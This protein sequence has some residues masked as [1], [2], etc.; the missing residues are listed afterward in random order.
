MERDLQRFVTLLS[1]MKVDRADSLFWSITLLLLML[2]HLQILIIVDWLIYDMSVEK[3]DCFGVFF[4][5][6]YVHCLT[7]S[8]SSSEELC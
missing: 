8:M 5:F 4:Q 6:L 1:V 3:Y 2:L 7:N